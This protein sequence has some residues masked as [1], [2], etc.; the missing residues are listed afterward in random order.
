MFVLIEFIDLPET[1]RASFGP[2]VCI[3]PMI[4][5]PYDNFIAYIHKIIILT[6]LS[7]FFFFLNT[8]FGSIYLPF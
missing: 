7:I 6:L 4:D 3:F 1:I 5:I 2:T 8:I